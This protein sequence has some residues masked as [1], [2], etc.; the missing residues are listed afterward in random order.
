MIYRMVPLSALEGLTARLRAQGL[1]FRVRYRGPHGAHRD[2]LK[3]N[4]RAATVYVA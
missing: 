1:K 3:A 2:T 4:A